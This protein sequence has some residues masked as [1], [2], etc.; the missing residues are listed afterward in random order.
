MTFTVVDPSSS[1][2]QWALRS[3]AKEIEQRFDTDFG[4]E[5][6]LELARTAYAPPHGL[7]VAP[8]GPAAP[9]VACGALHWLDDER[10][11]VK[12]MWVAPSYRGR[13]VASRLLAFLED[14]VRESGRT[15]V[16]L[17]TNAGLTEAIAMY[18]RSGY[19]RVERYNDNPHAQ[20]W[21]RKELR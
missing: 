3:Y 17:D 18:D 1:A 5:A 15:T 6:A 20:L 12:R 21:F 14:L 11:E 2:A 10:G 9:V 4:V 8:P 16:V 13:G 19:E 7:F